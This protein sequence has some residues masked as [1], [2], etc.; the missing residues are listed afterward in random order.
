FA[1]VLL[2][3]LAVAPRERAVEVVGHELHE[4]LAGEV[5]HRFPLDTA[6]ARPVPSS[7]LGAGV[8]AGWSRRA[9]ERYALPPSSSLRHRVAGSPAPAGAA[10]RRWRRR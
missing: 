6:R 9:R 1:D 10:A 8:L 7:A 4:L 5:S 3:A 2:E